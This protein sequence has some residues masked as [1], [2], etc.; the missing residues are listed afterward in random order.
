MNLRSGFDDNWP[1]PD[2]HSQTLQESAGINGRS[3]QRAGHEE[4]RWEGKAQSAET[5]WIDD[6]GIE[7]PSAREDG[8]LRALP[9]TPTLPSTPGFGM[10]IVLPGQ[11]L[12][13]VLARPG[14]PSSRGGKS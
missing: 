9:S 1:D 10:K 8:D 12:S 7:R 13:V 14:P 11:V 6:V 3:G 4:R 5:E 2:A